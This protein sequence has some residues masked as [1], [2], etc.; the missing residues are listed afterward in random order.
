MNAI[1]QKP[2]AWNRWGADDERGA[3]NFIGPEQVKRAS[4]LVRTGEVLRLAQLLSSKTPVPAHRCGL[5]HSNWPLPSRRKVR[6][7]QIRQVTLRDQ[8][9][10][11]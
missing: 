2:N 7:T 10:V 1:A 8:A 5:Q 3:L 9:N 4:A 11:A 6:L